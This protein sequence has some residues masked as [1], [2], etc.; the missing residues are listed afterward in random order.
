MATHWQINVSVN[1]TRYV[2]LVHDVVPTR[3]KCWNLSQFTNKT[4]LIL[5]FYVVLLRIH[6]RPFIF[7]LTV[8][9]CDFYVFYLFSVRLAF[10]G[11]AWSFG[12]FS[13]P[14][15]RPMTFDFEGFSIPDFIHYICVLFLFFR[16]SQYFHVLMLSAKQGNYWY[17]FYN[18][19]GMTRSLTGDWNWDLPH[20]MPALYH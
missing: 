14:P 18:V 5:A 4:L 15:Q 1:N 11:S 2:F 8:D 16:K 17:D 3:K 10:V 6:F 7:C 12:F 13:S 9:R 20:S 19:F